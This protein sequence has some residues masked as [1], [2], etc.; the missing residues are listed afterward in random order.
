[1][2]RD[3]LS[4][5][6]LGRRCLCTPVRRRAASP[7]AIARLNDYRGLEAWVQAQKG[8]FSGQHSLLLTFAEDALHG[9]KSE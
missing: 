6:L 8:R 4:L 2:H 5:S 9:N 3:E 1:M 7:K